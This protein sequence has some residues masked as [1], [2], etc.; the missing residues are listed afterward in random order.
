MK[1]IA[2]SI[3]LTAAIATFVGLSPAQQALAGDY[4][5]GA[6]KQCQYQGHMKKGHHPFGK[7]KS[8][9]GLSAKQDQEIKDIFEKSRAQT[10]PLMEQLKKERHA[11]WAL[12]NADT[13]DEAAIRAQSATMASI[14]ADLAVQRA[15]TMKQ[16]RAVLTPEQ[17]EKLK[18][19]RKKHGHKAE[20]RQ[21]QR[22]GHG[23]TK[24]IKQDK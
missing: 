21:H 23:H 22:H 20:K 9:L 17:A 11:L 13:I 6:P 15:H 1:N 10:K 18:E 2:K 12:M 3:I 5:P 8:K 19:F 16:F 7:M 24:Q 4:D 14:K